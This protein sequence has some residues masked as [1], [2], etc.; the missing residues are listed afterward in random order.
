[1]YKNEYLFFIVYVVCSGKF[2]KDF[3]N[4]F[5]QQPRYGNNSIPLGRHT[6]HQLTQH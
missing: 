3:F 2:R 6:T 4:L 5:R 1:M